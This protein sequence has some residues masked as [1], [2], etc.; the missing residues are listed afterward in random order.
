MITSLPVIGWAQIL[1]GAVF[2]IGLALLL[3]SRLM[4]KRQNGGSPTELRLFV[5]GAALC[6]LASVFGWIAL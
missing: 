2:L 1:T 6:L 3:T 5:A 4:R